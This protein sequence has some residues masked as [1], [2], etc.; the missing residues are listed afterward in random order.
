MKALKVKTLMTGCGE[1]DCPIASLIR[2]PVDYAILAP[3]LTALADSRGKSAS[4]AAL[5]AFIR[6]LD[7]QVI[8]DGVQ[9][10]AQIS[11]LS[12]AD[13]YGYIPSSGYQGTV[14]HGKLRMT[15]TEVLEL[16]REETY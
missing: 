9:N 2:V 12:R 13:S 8:G 4:V 1:T 10:D 15:L 11:A 6:S 5:T 16:M 14:E 7:I 3:W